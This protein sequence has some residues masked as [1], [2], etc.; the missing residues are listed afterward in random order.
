MKYSPVTD[1][2][3]Y[4]PLLPIDYSDPDVIRVGQDY[5]MVAS[6]FTYLPG[7]P[8][9]HS[10][11]LIHWEQLAW[12]VQSLPFSRYDQP[13][14]GCGTW[15]PAIRWHQGTFYVFI[16]LP[17]EGIFVTTAAD[18]AGPWS[19][20]HCV[21]KACGWIDPCP[22]WDKDGNAYMVHAYAKSRC[23]IKH[24]IDICRMA[25]DASRLLD[26]G[27]EVYNNPQMHPTMEGPKMYW[28][29]GWY[30]I[31]APAGGVGSGW[32]TVLRSRAPA[33][34]Y[35]AR[36]VLHQGN[37]KVNGPHQGAWVTT[38]EGKDW[39]FHFQDAGIHGRILHLQPM[40]WVDGWPFIGQDQNGDGVGEPVTSW[41]LPLP[42]A[43]NVGFLAADDDFLGTTP[44]IQW[45]WQANPRAEWY[46]MSHGL[47]LYMPVCARRQ[48]LL[49]YMPN[50]LT[51]SARALTYAMQTSLTLQAE[52]CGDEGGIA[53]MGHSYAALALQKQNKG[54]SLVLYKGTVTQRTP[55]G[56]AEELVC[57]TIPVEGNTVTLRLC[58][59]ADDTVCFA[60]AQ[61]GGS[62]T[63]LPGNYPVDKS[64]WSGARPGLFARNV[65]N[66][67]TKSSAR[68]EKLL[69]TGED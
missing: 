30:Y 62:F 53:L 6:S 45:Q 37:S 50:V 8:L 9:L 52:R 56:T 28:R 67:A 49:W 29:D 42:Q 27:I 1:D 64:T 59:L 65:Y 58:L 36:I 55:Q 19:P 69:F 39:F 13:V 16:P 4:N 14:H 44:G 34:P 17:D 33:G 47:Q 40:C 32:Q 3:Y 7:V 25:A 48:S 63:I 46:C 57:A 35:E 20:L 31:F 61:P 21:K 12:C 15:A 10:K 68:F 51:Q 23:G 11:D 66:T 5:Y 18:P 2:N 24:R 22:F 54:N 38:P 26:D 60:Y 41:P 43:P